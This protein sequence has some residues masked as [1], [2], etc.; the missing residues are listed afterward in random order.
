MHWNYKKYVMENMTQNSIY[1][2]NKF[3]FDVQKI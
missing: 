3:E 1:Y 2:E